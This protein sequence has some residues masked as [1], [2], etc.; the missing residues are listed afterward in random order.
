MGTASDTQAEDFGFKQSS[1]KRQDIIGQI[2][3]NIFLLHTQTFDKGE[4]LVV[5]EGDK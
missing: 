3:K 1:E 2:E 5:A 4:F